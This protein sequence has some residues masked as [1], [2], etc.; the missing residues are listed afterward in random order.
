MV[1][2]KGT[3]EP[4]LV[5]QAG[6]KCVKLRR[7]NGKAQSISALVVKWVKSQTILPHPIDQNEL[8]LNISFNSRLLDFIFF[9]LVNYCFCYNKQVQAVLVYF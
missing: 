6:F 7:T 8:V 1:T 4:S 2:E 9:H 3:L 5:R